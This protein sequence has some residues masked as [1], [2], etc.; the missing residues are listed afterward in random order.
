MWCVCDVC[1]CVCVFDFIYNIC[2]RS[3]VLVWT[4]HG[5]QNLGFARAPHNH[6]HIQ[7][8]MYVYIYIHTACIIVYIYIQLHVHSVDTAY[9]SYTRAHVKSC[10]LSPSDKISCE[11]LHRT[12]HN[13]N[14]GHLGWRKACCCRCFAANS[15]VWSRQISW[16]ITPFFGSCASFGIFFLL[17]LATL[18][19][20]IWSSSAA[21]PHHVSVWHV[22]VLCR[23]VAA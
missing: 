23:T 4:L 11:E 17:W 1:V 16:S 10:N 21:H 22:S 9:S 15:V 12:M 7:S 18:Q 13:R 19:G 3:M 5:R 14:S 6:L 8:C 20:C 2:L